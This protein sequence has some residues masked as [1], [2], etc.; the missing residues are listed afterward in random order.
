MTHKG[1]FYFIDA[2]AEF[3]GT[4]I[5]AVHDLW[6]VLIA[7]S[8]KWL[9]MDETEFSWIL[10]PNYCTVEVLLHVTSEKTNA[11]IYIGTYDTSAN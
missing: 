5:K 8:R 2:Y 3:Y 6:Y 1:L 11:L 7:R 4:T 10:S 9:S